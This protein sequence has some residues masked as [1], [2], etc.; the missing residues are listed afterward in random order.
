MQLL[1]VCF[2]LLFVARGGVNDLEF[3]LLSLSEKGDC[4]S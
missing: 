3:H 4:Q 1:Y 2:L